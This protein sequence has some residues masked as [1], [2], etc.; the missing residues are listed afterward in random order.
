MTSLKNVSLKGKKVLLRVDFNVPLDSQCHI[1]DD[2]RIKAALPTIRHII[3]QGASVVLMSHLGRPKGQKNA[4]YSLKPCAE[5]LSEILGK[6]VLFAPDCIG[7]ETKELVDKLSPGEVLLL[8]NLRFH[9]AEEHPEDDTAFAGQLASYGDIYVNDAFGTAHRKHASTYFVPTL[10]SGKAFSGFLMEREIE[11]LHNI[12]K[13][14]KRPFYVILGGSKISDKC[15]VIAALMKIAD[16]VLIGGGMTYTFLKAQGIAI[17]NSIHEDAF[18]EQARQLELL[19]K[20]PG[21]GRLILPVDLLVADHLSENAATQVVRST[22]GIPAGYEG[23]DIGPR[24][25]EYYTAELRQAATIFWNGPVGVFEIPL[26]AKGTNAL[27]DAMAHLSAITIV[28]GGDSVAAIQ[29]AGVADKITHL[30]TGGGA[31]LEYIEFGSLPGV[32]VLYT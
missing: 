6:K 32:D 3:G 28:G 20:L 29:A 7:K 31:C 27:A 2:T 18:L 10:F 30:S 21:Y 22:D 16:Y 5:H 24:T 14:P 1:T 12:I 11:Y 4:K 13:N 26:F 15:G 25:I 9:P 8:E 23:V 17:G 19:S